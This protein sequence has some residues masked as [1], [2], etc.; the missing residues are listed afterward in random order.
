MDLARPDHPLL[1]ELLVNAPGTYQHSLQVSNLAEQAAKVINA[2]ALLTRVGCLY[3]DVGKLKN[4]MFFIENQPQ[5]QI[6]THDNLDPVITSATIVKHVEDGMKLAQEYHLPPQIAAFISEH[7]A[8]SLTRYQYKQAV[9]KSGGEDKVDAGLFRYPGPNPNSKET[10]LL[11]L[12]DSCEARVRAESPE[13]IERIRE[14]VGEV[15]NLY[16]NKGYLS[17]TDLTLNDLKLIIESF[18]KTLR[19]SYHQRVKY[20]KEE[21]SS[22]QDEQ[23]PPE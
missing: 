9:E 15:V 17:N 11:M 3:H 22:A 18:T 12:A 6:N 1:Q 7:H 21:K 5:S 19:N 2:D 14:I 20:P 8:T 13:S 10:A 4:P 16:M 23:Q